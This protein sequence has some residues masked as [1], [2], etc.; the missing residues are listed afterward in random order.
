MAVQNWQKIEVNNLP[1][2][3]ATAFINNIKADLH[4]AN[5]VYIVLDNHNMAILIHIFYVVQIVV[6]IGNQ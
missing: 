2:V 3:P 5:T 4:D 6:V 1:G